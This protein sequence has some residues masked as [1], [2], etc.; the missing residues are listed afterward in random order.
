MAAKK[1]KVKSRSK[2]KG[3]QGPVSKGA[4]DAVSPRNKGEISFV[5]GTSTNKSPAIRGLTPK[6][7][8]SKKKR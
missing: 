4:Y 1:K 8:S 7:Q 5:L 6:G 3:P 2:T